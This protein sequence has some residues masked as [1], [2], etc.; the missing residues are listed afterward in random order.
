MRKAL[1]LLPTL[2]LVAFVSYG[3]G[4]VI[5]GKVTD[6]TNKAVPFASIAVKNQI[7]GTAISGVSAD[8]NGSFSIDVGSSKTLTVTAAGFASKEVQIPDGVNTINVEM[9]RSGE[10]IQEVVVTALGIRRTRNQLPFAAQTVDGSEVSKSR[11]SNFVQNLSGKVAGLDIKQTNTLGGS[12]NVVI[13]GVKSITGDNQALFVVDGVPFNNANTNTG[14]QRTGRGGYDYGNAAADINPDDIESITVLKGAA[15]TALYGSQGGNGV[16]LITTKKGTRGLGVTVNSGITVGK[17]DKSTFAEYQKEY[18]GGYGAYYEDPNGFF[19]Y[20]DI[21]GDGV[22]DL[23]TPLSEDAS[24]GGRFDPNL[25]VYQWDAFDPASP[26]FGKARPWIAAANDPSDFFETSVSSNQSI[27]LDGGSDRG[28]FKLGYTRNDDKGILPNSKIKKNLLNF[29]GTYN[30]AKNLTAGASVNFSNIEGKGRYGTGYDDKNLATNFRQWFQTNVDIKEQKE[31]YFRN[32]KN[33]TWNWADPTD[34]TPIYWDNPYFTRYENYENDNRNRYF[35]NANLNYKPT[36]WLNILGRVSLDSYDELQEERQALG[37][38]TTSQYQRFNRSYRETNFNLLATV[39]KDIST[40]FN[41]K[42]L[43]GTGIRRQ[44]ISSI[45]ASTNGGLIV[46]KI[47]SLSNSANPINPPVEFDG[48]REV[49]GVYAGATLTYQ[50]MLTLDATIRR[51]QSSTLPEE[52]NVYYYPSASVGF[53]FSKLIPDASWLTYGKLRA[54]Y[55]Q[56]G[57]DAP[58]YSVFDTY[59]IIPPFG[60]NAQAS[61]NS[62]RNNPN[63]KPERTQS[64]E[65]GVEMQFLKSRAGLDFTYYRAK[66]IDQILPVIVSTS[67]GYSSK[68]LNAGTVEN[69]GIE[70]SLYGS[71][72]KNRDFTWNMNVNFTRNRNRVLELFKSESGKSADNLVLASFQGGVSLNATL[73]QPYGTI[74]GS[75]YVYTNGRKTVG[76]T[77]RYLIS[78]TSNEII[79][80][81][82]PDWIAGINNSFT[83]KNFTFSFLIDSKHGGDVFTLDLYYGLATGLYPE[84][85]GLNDLGNP[86]RNSIADGGGIIMPGVTADGKENDTRVS[87]TNY[88]SYGYV[89]N[90]AAGFVYDASYVKLREALISYSLPASTVEKLGGVFKGIDLSLVGRNLWIIHKNLPYADPEEAI[91][92]GNLQGYQGGAYPTT[93]TLTLNLKIRL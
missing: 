60:S 29:G 64:Y 81:P 8:V 72:V 28:S 82:N 91:S 14:N 10:V 4:R 79:G 33:V 85:A 48:T 21:D 88:G 84:T 19:L 71:P 54:N 51:D 43:L 32:H 78:T 17:I 3:Q 44:H 74:R 23:V 26:N 25:M 34:L 1:M 16:I 80:D 70:L 7:T 69:K 15:A 45:Y 42:A 20:R 58:I 55:A 83:Y 36:D 76:A 59:S 31:A 66:T 67:T 47:Y 2:L 12:T 41:F 65:A 40:N 6:E 24:Y 92:S 5:T 87:N 73:D 18:G 9:S 77:G 13:R 39:D 75:N 56:V 89:R 22:K 27:F 62:T 35:G 63:L 46:E 11:T 90:P 68:F 30:V 52:N 53:V 61:V 50:D 38:V 49:D 37:S 57:N 86:S 93:R